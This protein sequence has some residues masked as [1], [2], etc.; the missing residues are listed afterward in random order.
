MHGGRVDSDRFPLFEHAARLDGARGEVGSGRCV[1]VTDE[2]TLEYVS[3][4]PHGMEGGTATP[5]TPPPPSPHAQTGPGLY[6]TSG[7][8]LYP[9]AA[10][11]GE[12]SPT[13][14]LYD[15]VVDP[16]VR[17]VAAGFNGSVLAYGEGRPQGWKW[18]GGAGAVLVPQHVSR[19]V[20]WWCAPAGQTGS[21]K[22]HT[23]TGLNPLIAQRLFA[24]LQADAAA[25]EFTVRV[26]VVE[27]RG[28]CGTTNRPQ[29]AAALSSD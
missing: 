7:P 24:L 3:D 8:P 29:L 14:A 19:S 1:V 20:V 5:V 10:V 26:S 12:S 18:E 17:D 9:F 27:V 13:G 15:R 28:P 2:R 16:I 22:T 25:Y 23:I 6:A 4:G 21:G 11:F